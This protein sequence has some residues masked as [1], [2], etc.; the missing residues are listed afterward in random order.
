[1]LYYIALLYL[2]ELNVVNSCVCE[3][4]DSYGKNCDPVDLARVEQYLS[5]LTLKGTLTININHFACNSV[6]QPTDP[7]IL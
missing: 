2:N 7:K 6:T 5:T 3:P 4:I 1:M